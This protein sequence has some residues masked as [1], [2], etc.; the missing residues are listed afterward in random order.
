MSNY[1]EEQTKILI[2]TYMDDPSR[3]TVERLSQE[4]NRSL[5]SI[6]GKLSREGV[7]QRESYKTKTGEKPITKIELVHQIAESLKVD[8]EELLGLDKA[9]KQALKF[10]Q[11]HI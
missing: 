9:P 6:I 3:L 4:Y 10:L 5:K 1:S 7:Y 2:S 11:T 8:P